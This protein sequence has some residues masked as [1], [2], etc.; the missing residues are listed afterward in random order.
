MHLYLYMVGIF[1]RVAHPIKMTVSIH[2]KTV[3]ILLFFYQWRSWHYY[4]R[5]LILICSHLHFADIKAHYRKLN[6][7]VFKAVLFLA[8]TPVR[9]KYKVRSHKLLFIVLYNI[10]LWFIK[11]YSRR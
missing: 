1:I 2:S 3:L 8:L 4:L 10:A 11:N 9:L 6:R 7:C 5:V